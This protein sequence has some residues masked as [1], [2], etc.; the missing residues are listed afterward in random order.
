MFLHSFGGKR[1]GG[2]V[3][4]QLT[5]Y[6][7]A[8][9]QHSI[10]L[11]TAAP[12]NGEKKKTL[13]IANVSKRIDDV[14]QRNRNNPK[15]EEKLGKAVCRKENSNH[16]ARLRWFVKQKVKTHHRHYHG[17]KMTG[18]TGLQCSVTEYKHY[19]KCKY[20]YI[21]CHYQSTWTLLLI[22]ASSI[23]MGMK[24][25]TGKKIQFI[26]YHGRVVRQRLMTFSQGYPTFFC[27]S[28]LI[29]SKC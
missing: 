18:I 24:K 15:K 7:R 27:S 2:K 4:S 5:G 10:T 29:C 25:V 22:L 3:A 20:V 23:Y 14:K 19:I 11:A 17:S 26:C 28:A 8:C 9:S 12:R 6:T 16:R 13:W 21:G 1:T